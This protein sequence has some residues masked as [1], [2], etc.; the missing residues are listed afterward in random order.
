[1]FFDCMDKLGFFVTKHVAVQ[2]L[3]FAL[4][5]FRKLKERTA[6]EGNRVDCIEK[7]EGELAALRAEMAELKK[8][9]PKDEP[10]QASLDLNQKSGT[11][12]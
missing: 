9:L 11:G 2:I 3:S 4:F 6:E 8:A 12:T 7:L 1:M 5:T 10:V